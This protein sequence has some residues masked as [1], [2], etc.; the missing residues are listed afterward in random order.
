MTARVRAVTGLCLAALMLA[1]PA[2]AYLHLTTVRA[3][4]VVPVRWA[5]ARV[6][7]AMH[8]RGTVG[9]S[10]ADL[11]AALSRAFQAWQAAPETAV[12]FDY[13]GPTSSRPFEDDTVTVFGFLDEPDQD[14]VLGATSIVVDTVTGSIVEA[15]VFL[16]AAFPWSTAPAGAAGAFDVQSVATHEIGHLLGLGHSALGET[17]LRADGRR[18]VQASASVMFPIALGRGSTADRELQPDDVAG[19]SVLYPAPGAAGVRGAIRGRVR[20]GGRGV[21]RAHVVAFSP[22]TGAL[23]GGF[24]LGTDGDFQI[25]GLRP[26]PYVLRAEPL[27]D[28]DVESFLSSRTIELGFQPAV[29]DRLVVAPRGG[30]SAGVD[31]DVQPK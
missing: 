21:P 8:D 13:L 6:S 28:G 11:Q 9:V 23:V 3:G 24:A 7:W 10:P 4:S 31:L 14:R 25:E 12:A 17:T 30:A 22:V 15:D 20:L 5:G 2:A 26:G 1:A 18:D 29:H 19:I 27:D 16:N